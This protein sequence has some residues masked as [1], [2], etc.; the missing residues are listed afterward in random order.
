MRYHP[1][2]LRKETRHERAVVVVVERVVVKVRVVVVVATR[3]TFARKHVT[4][5]G[6]N[7]QDASDPSTDGGATNRT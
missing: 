6:R 1:L 4:S 5:N 2:R 7:D 3:S